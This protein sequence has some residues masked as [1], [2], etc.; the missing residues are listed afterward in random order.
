MRA[1]TLPALAIPALSSQPQPTTKKATARAPRR[2]AAAVLQAAVFLIVGVFVGRQSVV[3]FGSVGDGS[4]HSSNRPTGGDASRLS[5]QQQQ[6]QQQPPMPYRPA[7][8]ERTVLAQAVPLGYGNE[9]NFGD[10]CNIWHDSNATTTTTA[11]LSSQTHQQLQAYRRE[12]AHYNQLV[13]DFLLDDAVRKLALRLPA[14]ASNDKN[15]KVRDIRTLF[16][17]KEQAC[18]ALALHPDGLEGLFAPHHLSQLPRHL[19]YAEPLLPPL[20]HHNLCFSDSQP[21][22]QWEDLF[23]MSYMIHDF[24][25]MCHALT[26]T[27]RIILVD[28]GASLAYHKNHNTDDQPALYLTD[29][30]AKFGL[31][32]DHIYAYEITPQDPNVVVDLVPPALQAAY[33]W[34]NVGVNA[35]P[36]SR[37]NPLQLLLDHYT[38]DDLIVAKLDIDTPAIEIA[39]IDW[40]Q[41]NPQLA[42]LI[43]HFYFEHHVRIL[44]LKQW[45]GRR[46]SKGSVQ[47]SL[48]LFGA[49]R[50]LGIAAH[51]WV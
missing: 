3:M 21:V 25:A 50:E 36:G 30:Y 42:T 1:R 2:P 48:Q 19:G 32:F 15:N 41:S 27:S 35:T 38:A 9:R 29:L 44:Q 12:L 18:Q 17:E 22:V 47:D 16:H 6:Q 46:H 23:D 31:P 11:L 43:D 37:H 28:M 20:R 34:I 33:H 8:M 26:P 40:I 39:L 24:R 7:A 10:G 5:S 45:W 51:Y 13:K 49:L 4:L 14:A